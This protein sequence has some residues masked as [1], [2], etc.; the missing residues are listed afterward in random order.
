M[1]IVVTNK[2]NYSAKYILIFIY[3]F[4]VAIKSLYFTLLYIKKTRIPKL[5][6][7]VFVF[8]DFPLFA[9]L[10]ICLVMTFD[11]HY[12]FWILFTNMYE[13]KIFRSQP[14]KSIKVGLQFNKNVFPYRIDGYLRRCT[15]S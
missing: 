8:Q 6:F 13:I 10:R 15:A 11:L 1:C 9:K 4:Q 12:L 7:F 5:I 14:Y 2:W 3:V